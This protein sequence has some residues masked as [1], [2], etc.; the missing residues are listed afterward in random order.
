M[1]DCLIRVYLS[2]AEWLC[3]RLPEAERAF[4]SSIARWW[5]AGEAFWVVRVCELLGL[6]QRARGRLDAAAAT[7]RQAREAA[8][9]PGHRTLAGAGI[10]DV[11][12][13]EVAYQRNELDAALRTVTEGIALCRQFSYTQP[14]AAG[15]A[16][17]AWIRQAAG[18][19][20]GAREAIAEAK[21]AAPGPAGVLNP[22]PAQGARLL[23]VQGNLAEAA[24][25][26]Q[27]CGLGPDDDPV[28][29][30]NLGTWCWPGFCSPK[31]RPSGR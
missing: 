13:A 29:P 18:D 7:Y 24:R 11:G 22:I 14:L 4:G 25:W 5:A 1:L 27:E 12:L 26:A 20:A 31:G 3:G 30:G 8:A 28:Y 23:L 2:V 10:G 17:L 16:T 9:P 21:Q 6:V 15:L 19:P